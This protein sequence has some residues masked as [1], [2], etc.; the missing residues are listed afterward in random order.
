MVLLNHTVCEKRFC[1]VVSGILVA[2]HPTGSE[3]KFH[4][5]QALCLALALCQ[6][7]EAAFVCKR[8]SLAFA[9][10]LSVSIL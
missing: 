2:S 1:N 9:N 3:T 7:G 8:A 5:V 10:C 6:H 4:L